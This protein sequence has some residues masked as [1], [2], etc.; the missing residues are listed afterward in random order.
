VKTRRQQA[1]LLSALIV[2]ALVF[3]FVVLPREIQEGFAS[4]GPGLSPRAMPE[5]AVAGIIL[6]LAFGLISSFFA[7]APSTDAPATPPGL[8]AHPLRSLGALVVCLVFAYLGFSLLGFYLGGLLMATLLTLLLG[9]RQV[10]KVLVIPILTLVV[11]YCVFELG[12]QVRLPKAG[13][14]PGVPI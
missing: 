1:L 10:V 7:A 6:A 13:F 14:I 3:A 2:L 12:F 11:I 9:E 8:A 5:L 4:G